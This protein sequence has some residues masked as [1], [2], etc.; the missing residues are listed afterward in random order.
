M[1]RS[2][3]TRRPAAPLV[4]R[5]D[6]DCEAEGPSALRLVR[7][8]FFVFGTF[9]PE[10]T[11]YRICRVGHELNPRSGSGLAPAEIVRRL[12]G[13]FAYVD[14]DAEAGMRRALALADWIEARPAS[15]FLGHHLVAL[16]HAKQLR[17]LSPDDALKITSVPTPTAR[18]FVL[19][20]CRTSR[21][22]SDTRRMK[23]SN[24]FV[25]SWID[26]PRRSTATSWIFD[27]RLASSL[28]ISDFGKSP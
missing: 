13:E 15:L 4:S 7:R 6:R 26:V 3:S 5:A 21:S 25:R 9:R 27:R 24:I 19:S 10:T 12:R 18:P 23:R 28:P 8:S 22:S 16:A 11:P 20:F 2:K 1:Q 17:N 14:V